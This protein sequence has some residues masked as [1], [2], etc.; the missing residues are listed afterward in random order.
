MEKS[1]PRAEGQEELVIFLTL[2]LCI[3]QSPW[4]PSWRRSK[5]SWGPGV[6]AAKPC[7]AGR[8]EVI[9]EGKLSPLAYRQQS[10]S[11][12]TYCHWLLVKVQHLLLEEG[13]GQESGAASAQIPE[14][15]TGFQ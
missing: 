6:G 15:P 8:G 3:L 1:N 13:A 7:S 9:T 14:L 11:T 2:T 4:D 10:Q 5:G 12:D